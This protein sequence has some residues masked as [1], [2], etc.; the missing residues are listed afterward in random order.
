VRVYVDA[1]EPSAPT[2]ALPGQP[3]SVAATRTGSGKLKI[4]WT[5]PAS[6]GGSTI[7]G[8]TVSSTKTTKTCTATTT[9]CTIRGLTNG[10]NYTF[11]VT[12]TNA[13]GSGS[14]SKASA[15]AHP[16]ATLKATWKVAGRTV[17]VTWKRVAKQ[18]KHALT[19]GLK[20]KKQKSGTCS[21]TTKKVTCTITLK[22]GTNTLTAYAYTSSKVSIAQATTTKKTKKNS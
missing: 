7:T 9:S 8:Y 3:T 16:Y 15:K 17:T 2:G 13:A 20:G 5:A 11:T 19:G 14:A 12:A 1:T 18:K 21:A 4:T 22:Q 10:T 6:N